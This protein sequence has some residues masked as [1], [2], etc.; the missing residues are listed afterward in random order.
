MVEGFKLTAEKIKRI[1]KL[2]VHLPDDY[3][4]NNKS[5]PLLLVFDGGIF[6]SYLNEDNKQI[7]LK[8]ILDKYNKEFIT[9]GLF[10]PRL[11]EWNISELNPYYSGNMEGV[12]IS[13]SLI[14]T[15]YVINE[16]IPLLKQK[17]RF[18][19]NISVMGYDMGASTVISILAKYDKIKKGIMFSLPFSEMNDL[20]FDDLYKINNKTVYV[21]QGLK[22]IPDDIKD[23][24]LK[25]NEYFENSNITYYI[26]SDNHSTN[27]TDDIKVRIM[28]G[29]EVI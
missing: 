18:N 24:Y 7:D 29:L 22:D 25:L 19:D 28:N 6:F 15:E 13:Y 17:Y 26:D 23:K 20:M 12:D 9:I 1:L 16:L 4:T 10:K 27:T 2:S 5:Y 8:E 14:F 21:Y 3:Y 11:E